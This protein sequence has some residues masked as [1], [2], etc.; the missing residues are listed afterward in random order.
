MEWRIILSGNSAELGDL[1]QAL[2]GADVTIRRE[3][4][5][6][7]LRAS[8]LQ[9]LD[10]ADAVK[11]EAER[12]IAHLDGA[13]RLAFNARTPIC[14]KTIG[15]WDEGGKRY[16]LSLTTAAPT[17]STLGSAL[18]F[19]DAYAEE[20]TSPNPLAV[21]VRIAD[22]NENVAK[23]LRLLGNRRMNWGDLYRLIEVVEYDLGGRDE[24]KKR[25]WA[26]ED[27]LARFRHTANSVAVSGDNARHGKE[28]TRPPARPLTLDEGQAFV[29]S[30]IRAWLE[31]RVQA[32]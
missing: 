28:Y 20:M 21:W 13:A 32:V 5:E 3:G 4:E 19:E 12:L 17:R 7:V 1:S 24:I 2:T 23:A 14:V 11:D 10:S 31:F 18:L 8:S 30:V 16:F 26:T 6:Y 22:D 15:Y 9:A 29:E 25:G 27:A